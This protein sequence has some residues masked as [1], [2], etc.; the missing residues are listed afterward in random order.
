MCVLADIRNIHTY[1]E[2][3]LFVYICVISVNGCKLLDKTVNYKSDY[4]VAI[5]VQ[6]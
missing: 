6:Y 5:V 3:Y 2:L 4:V 1:A